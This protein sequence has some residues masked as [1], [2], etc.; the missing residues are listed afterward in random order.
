MSKGR[1]EGGGGGGGEKER[2]K[3]KLSI[4]HIVSS[5]QPRLPSHCS[6]CVRR[7]QRERERERRTR[8]FSLAFED[9]IL[10]CLSEQRGKRRARKRV[11]EAK[12]GKENV[13]FTFHDVTDPFAFHSC[14][15]L[16]PGCF[17]TSGSSSSRCFLPL[18]SSPPQTSCAC[19]WVCV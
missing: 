9:I 13:L 3:N 1:K 2:T 17:Q 18:R 16:F 6:C 8:R 4:E 10:H 15:V 19:V 7:R 12:D 5:S 11:R 14:L